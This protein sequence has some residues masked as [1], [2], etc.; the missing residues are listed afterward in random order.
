[1]SQLV[2]YSLN[3]SCSFPLSFNRDEIK[4]VSYFATVTVEQTQQHPPSNT[5]PEPTESHLPPPFHSQYRLL[6]NYRY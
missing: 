3:F 5:I 6:S 4:V 2:E 1:M